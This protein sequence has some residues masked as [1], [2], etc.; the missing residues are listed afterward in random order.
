MS[1]GGGGGQN[2]AN[3]DA[4]Y[5]VQT[6]Q[7]KRLMGLSEELVYPQY[8]RLSEQANDYDSFDNR[9]RQAA[10]AGADAAAASDRDRRAMMDD[11]TSY[12]I[13]PGDQRFIN[14]ANVSNIQGAAQSAA[15]RTG[16]RDKV[17]QTGFAR[18]LDV[19]GM[20]S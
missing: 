10:T 20:L 16:A 9:E 6:D 18:G 11:L 13:G 8:R 19:A 4:L 3:L 7:A 15:A 1:G 14:A 17:S 2:Y 12:G 5:G